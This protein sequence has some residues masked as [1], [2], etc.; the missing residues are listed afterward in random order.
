MKKTALILASV[1]ALTAGQAG[2]S[3]DAA[4][5]KSKAGACIGCHGDRNWPGIFFTLQLAGRDADKLT[6]KTN[7][8]RTFKIVHPM[9]NMVVMG[10]SD[11]DVE[12]ISAFYRSLEKPAFVSP[13][14]PIRGD[15]EEP[16]AAVISA[17]K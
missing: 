5:G 10:L 12:D 13:F 17:G 15:D 3:G 11:R 1:L 2:A 9:M 6:V 14:H 16:A 8:Y 7:K 4:A